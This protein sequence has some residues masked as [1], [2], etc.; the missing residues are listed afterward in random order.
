MIV[1]NQPQLHLTYCLNV[2]P[3][4]RWAANFAAI[5]QKASAIKER[6]AP[7]QWFGLGLRLS[8]HAAQDLSSPGERGGLLDVCAEEQLCA[9]GINGFAGGNFHQARVKGDVYA[10]DSRAPQRLRFG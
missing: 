3:G 9:F 6:V 8:A 7:D 10:P 5:Q 4:E 2:H 1:Q